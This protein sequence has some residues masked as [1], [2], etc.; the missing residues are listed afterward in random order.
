MSVI[1]TDNFNRSGALGANYTVQAGTFNCDGVVAHVTTPNALN[2]AIVSAISLPNNAQATITLTFKGNNYAGIGIRG[3]AGSATGYYLRVN[4]T[5]IELRSRGLGGT[6]LATV[7]FTVNNGDIISIKAVG[8]TI[9]GYV[10]GVQQITATDSTYTTGSAGFGGGY[11]A[12]AINQ[13]T[14]DDLSLDNLLP[15]TT[16]STTSSSTT[17]STTTTTS[18]S[19]TTSSTTSS[20]TSS[21]PYEYHYD[22]IISTNNASLVAGLN[23]LGDVGWEMIAVVGQ[24]NVIGINGTV[25][26]TTFGLFKR[27]K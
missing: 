27:L 2:Q 4:A 18:S 24:L 8:T 5:T 20:S 1:F 17:S 26:T 7:T 25:T 21:L 11:T 12:T 6:V 15:Y 19:T 13:P 9:T 3:G 14:F 10:N 23:A 16:T 22:Q